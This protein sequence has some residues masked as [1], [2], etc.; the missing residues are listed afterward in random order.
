[1]KEE[2]HK[3]KVF[4]YNEAHEYPITDDITLRIQIIS[5]AINTL[6]NYKF[7]KYLSN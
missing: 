6:K 7:N 4:P 1:M 5:L 2:K 3:I